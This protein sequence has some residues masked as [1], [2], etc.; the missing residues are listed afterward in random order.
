MPR[1]TYNQDVVINRLIERGIIRRI[2]RGWYR[3]SGNDSHLFNRDMLLLRYAE[4]VEPGRY[5][6]LGDVTRPVAPERPREVRR[7]N[8]DSY[9]SQSRNISS[10]LHRISRDADGAKRSYGVEYEING[11]TTSQ[12][13]DLAYL[14]DTLPAHVTERD[15]S[16]S[17]SGVEIVFEPMSE[18]EL[19]RVVKELGK[20]VRDN[21]VDMEGAGMHITYGFE[22]EAVYP[23]ERDLVIRL[24][25]LA[26]AVKAVATQGSIRELFGRDFTGYARL[27]QSLGDDT[28]YRAFN[29]RN[30]Y[31]WECRLV[32]WNCNIEK[33]V[34]L[35][36]AT[37]FVFTRPVQAADFIA[38]FNLLGA[39][40]EGI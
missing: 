24:N 16:L 2:R 26:L 7:I 39:N 25:R 23:S 36:K 9:R 27:P 33:M 17:S 11:L 15:G 1:V 19:V 30:S 6:L 8:R 10:A 18:Q 40:T 5:V 38:L 35:F 20:F 4:E 32:S 12:E 3:I 31:A 21:G 28:R 14:L 13:S 34:E 37:E 29:V 22:K